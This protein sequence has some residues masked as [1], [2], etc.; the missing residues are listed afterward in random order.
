M[1][2]GAPARRRVASL[3]EAGGFGWAGLVRLRRPS[4]KGGFA[5]RPAGAPQGIWGKMRGA[6]RLPALCR[7]SGWVA[8]WRRMAMMGAR[9][10]GRAA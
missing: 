6:A 5:P 9:Q 1:S 2:R 4:L 7:P 3:R 10:V 8:V